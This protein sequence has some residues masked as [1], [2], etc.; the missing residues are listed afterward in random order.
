MDRSILDRRTALKGAVATGASIWGIPSIAHAEEEDKDDADQGVGKKPQPLEYTPVYFIVYSNQPGS[1]AADRSEFGFTES[2]NFPLFGYNDKNGTGPCVQNNFDPAELEKLGGGEKL[3][4]ELS[5]TPSDSLVGTPEPY[6]IGHEED[7][8]YRSVTSI[9]FNP[10]TQSSDFNGIPNPWAF[11]NESDKWRA[12]VTDRIIL[13]SK[14]GEFEWAVTRADL[15]TRQNDSPTYFKSFVYLFWA[16]NPSSGNDFGTDPPYCAPQTD[17][18]TVVEEEG[19]DLI[20]DGL[21]SRGN[22]HDEDERE[23]KGNGDD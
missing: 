13:D 21:I 3:K 17:I 22:S 14:G 11:L 12:I 20:T 19:Q 6:T 8:T 5:F 23:E 9:N 18:P 16:D 2:P 4:T 7:G 1:D 10:P 15:Y